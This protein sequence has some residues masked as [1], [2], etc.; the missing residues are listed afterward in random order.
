VIIQKTG[1]NWEN[2]WQVFVDI[3]GSDSFNDN[4]NATLCEPDIEDCLLQVHD[5]LP[6][7]YTLR[8]KGFTNDNLIRYTPSGTINNNNGTFYLCDNIIGE[9][10]IP[11]YIPSP[12]MAKLV[13]INTI[14]R[15]RAG[16]DDNHN[17]IPEKVSNTDITTCTP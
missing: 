6:G 14:G 12:N 17:G 5:A 3:D 15:P 8:F 10:G 16:L 13:I 7:L 1:A 4:G 2:G 9:T 11:T